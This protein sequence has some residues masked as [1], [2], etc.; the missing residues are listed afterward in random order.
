MIWPEFEDENGI[1]ITDTDKHISRTGKA[2]MWIMAPKM[3][4]YHKDKIKV[5]LKGFFM[6]GGTRV[7]ECEVIEMVDLLIN[8]REPIEVKGRLYD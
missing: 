8:P 2:R 5:S 1:V 6:E 4:S 7:A 3:R